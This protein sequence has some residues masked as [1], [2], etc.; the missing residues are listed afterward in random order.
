MKHLKTLKTQDNLATSF[1]LYCV[2]EKKAEN[3]IYY[4]CV[5]NLNMLKL[6]ITRF[7]NGEICDDF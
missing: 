4:N 7:V 3:K 5:E 1:P 2:F 6:D